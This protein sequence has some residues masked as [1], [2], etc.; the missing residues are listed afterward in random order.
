MY[1]HHS[2]QQGPQSFSSGSRP[3][4]HQQLS[5]QQQSHPAADMMSQV[6]GFQF[7]RPTQLPDE[8]ESALAIRGSRDIDHRV[9][10]SMNIQNQHQTL[11]PGSDIGQCLSERGSYNSNPLTLTPDSQSGHQQGADWSK[12]QPQMTPF[13]SH[14]SSVSHQG[15]QQVSQS[16]HGGTCMSSWDT[17]MSD[18]PLSQ[19]RN[20]HGGRSSG[21]ADGQ[22][23]YT[24]ESAGSILASFGLSNEDL[25]V[26]SHY[27][28][29][30]LTP[31]TLPF[32]LREIQ[33][34]K[35]SKQNKDAPLAHSGT[36]E[37]P[38]LLTVTKTAG[39]VIDYGHA[40]RAKEESS[41]RETFKREPLSSERIVKMVYSSSTVPKLE[42]TERQVRLE[43]SKSNKHGDRDY[44]R[45]STDI[46]KISRS[47]KREFPPLSKS[48][49]V[50]HDYRRERHKMRPSSETRS[51][52][53]PFSRHTVSSSSGLKTQSSSKR[54]PT[55]S[56][57][58][59]FNALK[60]KMY[61]HTC[62][63]CHVEC[64]Q[65]KEWI[66]HV[67]TVNHTAAC[68]D[69]RNKKS[70]RYGRQ[71][72]W[73]PKEDP[74]P[75]YPSHSLSRTPS[76]PRKQH[77]GLHTPRLYRKPYARDYHQGDL[78][79]QRLRRS[80]YGSH[81]PD[82]STDTSHRR[83]TSKS[84]HSSAKTGSKNVPK[85]VS[86]AIK[87]TRGKDGDASP[88]AKKKKK[89]VTTTLQSTP[90]ANR[91]IYLT[92]IPLDAS[93]QDITDLVASFGKI[94]NVILMPGSEEEGEKNEGQK[95]SVCMV[96]A[97]DAK[98]LAHSTKLFIKDKQITALVAK[99]ILPDQLSSEN[100]NSASTQDKSAADE[101]SGSGDHN[102]ITDET[103]VL[104]TGLPDGGWSENDIT[105][106]VQP[107][108]TVL[109]IIKVPEMGKVLLSV[110][111]TES[112]QEMVKVLTFSPPKINDSEL[113]LF[114]LKQNIGMK[115]PVALYN[116][117]MGSVDPLENS[118]RVSWNC[119]LVISNVPDTP[120]G[121]SEVQKLVR[122]FGTVIRTL[123][124]PKSMVICEMA[125]GAMA[126]S[127][128][129]RFQKFPCMIENNPLCFSHKPDP[130]ATVQSKVIASFLDSSKDTCANKKGNQLQK[131]ADEEVGVD[132]ETCGSAT[133]GKE[134]D[135]D[136]K[137][138]SRMQDSEMECENEALGNDEGNDEGNEIH[139]MEVA[140]VAST[141]EK[142]KLEDDSEMEERETLHVEM[143]TETTEETQTCSES[144]A[145]NKEAPVGEDKE[146]VTCDEAA[147]SNETASPE[148][149]KLT[150]QMVNVLLEEY[151]SRTA[152]HSN[153]PKA[154][155]EKMEEQKEKPSR[156][157]VEE[158]KEI[159]KD[160]TEEG[161]E[162]KRERKERMMR[163]EKEQRERYERERKVWEE[164]RSRR[165]R[166]R[167]DRS[168]REW[169][170][171]ERDSRDRK[172]T[173][174]DV[175]SGSRSLS[176]SESNKHSFRKEGAEKTKKA[177]QENDGEFD[178]MFNMGDFVTV[179]EVGEVTDFPRS[180]SPSVAV[181]T[182]CKG[183]DSEAAVQQ[184]TVPDTISE[185]ATE[186]ESGSAP[187]LMD[188]ERELESETAP[189]AESLMAT[190]VVPAASPPQPAPSSNQTNTAACPEESEMET[191]TK[192]ELTSLET[193]DPVPELQSSSSPT[194]AATDGAVEAAVHPS[195]ETPASS[196]VTLDSEDKECAPSH[197]Q[198]T[199]QETA[200]V[201]SG[202]AEDQ[203]EEKS[204]LEA[205]TQ[206]GKCE[207][208]EE[209]T[210]TEEG[211]VTEKSKTDCSLPPFDPNNPVGMELLVPKTGFFCK[212]CGRFFSG[213]KEAE[214]NH[215]R[216]L[217]HYESLQK[218]LCS[219]KTINESAKSKSS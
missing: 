115:R 146:P 52:T 110:E 215:C 51:E 213:A 197:S 184:D 167:D 131:T 200:A 22:G 18:S 111:D 77:V 142:D 7:P 60:P 47:P 193:L 28:D 26:L 145:G 154:S 130:K 4:H 135:A 11:G 203:D 78:S 178:F 50:D 139:K 134:G 91:L 120:N 191:I 174:S 23:L 199:E 16:S 61:P 176:R 38:S 63:V 128:Y 189:D 205:P 75:V 70:G 214:V 218:Y 46:H 183:E 29:E 185:A 113:K 166:D 187:N 66:E 208:G 35:S 39:E 84:D 59:D 143:V 155:E 95:A 196:S 133:E 85:T 182:T 86:K 209:A 170:R 17:S 72:L 112:A 118:D 94:N 161:E 99:N 88:P 129:N 195:T 31:D 201:A 2:Q 90:T 147:A 219:K 204:H 44:R 137:D 188:S 98:A 97:E 190:D 49:P 8:L 206:A 179:D 15:P 48:R 30:Q 21:G 125:N 175:L 62:A 87:T 101:E 40:S 5:N 3:P 104:I 20:S 109:D 216:T 157:K 124:L 65:E 207:T 141:E 136:V 156:D 107:F 171:M 33:V 69:L 102:R 159:A 100:S 162:K 119:L 53:S 37:V 148:L 108:V 80:H 164:E 36:P 79:H 64:D 126:L 96:K 9:M 211:C 71:V 105:E 198:A 177:D 150:Q 32:I 158:L 117:L 82:R 123:V 6:G 202:K 103:K 74:T 127:V 192:T 14:P 217:K 169:E 93:E 45:A 12:Y 68:R 173:H 34:S 160:R 194:P 168:R 121:P 19:V 151:R 106:L 25:E 149:P 54:L 41:S 140:D 76:P 212:A 43:P 89:V 57:I 138:S 172:R 210:K 42:T 67:N 81:S 122:R 92:G 180:P 13:G 56:L 24:S 144:Q 165:V 73:D 116:L 163:R 152:N 132:R 55:P 153:K 58:N 27:P 1:H 83:P 181:D 10:D 114:H 186:K